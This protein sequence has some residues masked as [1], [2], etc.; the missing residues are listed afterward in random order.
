MFGPFGGVWATLFQWVVGLAVLYY[1]V[2][3]VF[4]V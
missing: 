4:T 1:A 3:T 2:T